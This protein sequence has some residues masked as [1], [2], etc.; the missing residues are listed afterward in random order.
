LDDAALFEGSRYDLSGSDKSLSVKD[1]I[2]AAFGSSVLPVTTVA[3]L[4][5]YRFRLI[6]KFAVR[7]LR[8]AAAKIIRETV[9]ES[10][11]ATAAVFMN[12]N[13]C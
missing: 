2:E 12:R 8:Y 10:L 6:C 4:I 11:R 13:S 9:T 3:T 1:V 5:Q 7:R